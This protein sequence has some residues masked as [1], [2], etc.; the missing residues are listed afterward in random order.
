MTKENKTIRQLLDQIG[1]TRDELRVKL[2]LAEMNLKEEW[3][4]LEEKL[5]GLAKIEELRDKARLE[6]HLA[7]MEAKD[8]LAEM[9]KTLD[10]LVD[11]INRHG[12][13]ISQEAKDTVT[14]LSERIRSYRDQFKK[15]A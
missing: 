14:A 6:A 12:D 5:R 15:S 13:E 1:R 2:H 10:A 7:R 9:R 3:D 11:G 4:Q 8:E